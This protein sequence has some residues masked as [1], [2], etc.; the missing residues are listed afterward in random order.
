MKLRPVFSDAEV[1]MADVVT[2][3]PDVSLSRQFLTAS[4]GQTSATVD[5][6]LPIVLDAS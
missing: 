3:E 2:G 6:L 4:L 1:T 5:E